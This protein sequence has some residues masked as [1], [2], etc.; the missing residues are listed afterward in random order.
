MNILL[1]NYIE[2]IRASKFKFDLILEELMSIKNYKIYNNTLFGSQS[3][4]NVNKTSNQTETDNLNKTSLTVLD[5]NILVNKSNSDS[6]S[7]SATDLNNNLYD[8]FDIFNENSIRNLGLVNRFMIRPAYEALKLKLETSIIDNLNTFK[9]IYIIILTIFI[10]AVF[11][12]YLFLWRPFENR[13]NATVIF[14]IFF[15]YI[16]IR[17]IKI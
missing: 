8:P 9:L 4:S 5:S 2:E 13:L 15:F 3:Y 1:T 7:V 10:S 16:L 17:I 12:V 14:I 11:F 6:V